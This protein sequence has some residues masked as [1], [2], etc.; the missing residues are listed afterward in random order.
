[1]RLFEENVWVTWQ[2]NAVQSRLVILV[3]AIALSV[4]FHQLGVSSN[5]KKIALYYQT[6]AFA[7]N[8]VSQAW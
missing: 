1:M 8:T 6:V 4:P 3:S 7:F 2:F 5:N